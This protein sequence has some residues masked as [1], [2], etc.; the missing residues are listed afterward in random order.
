[1]PTVVCSQKSW[2]NV[3]KYQEVV[4]ELSKMALLEN[5]EERILDEEK[6]NSVIQK[7]DS[8]KRV[9][10]MIE[11]FD[12]SE[13]IF[14]EKKLN[15][16]Q[17]IKFFIDQLKLRELNP[18][19]VKFMEYSNCKQITMPESEKSYKKHVEDVFK[20]VQEKKNFVI[21]FTPKEKENNCWM[22]IVDNKQN[23]LFVITWVVDSTD[24]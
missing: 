22:G 23:K 9:P 16:E 1:V 4:I 7:I 8:H 24:I 11:D 6:L 18:G 17:K 12:G 10:I 13:D 5:E 21:D 2:E 15:K 19:L 20:K 14:I 3:S